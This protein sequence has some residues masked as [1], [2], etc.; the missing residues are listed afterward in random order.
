MRAGSAPIA[1][2]AA[3]LRAAGG[4]G[5]VAV[6]AYGSH[7]ISAAPGRHS[8]YDLVVVVE[9]YTDFYSTLRAS[10]HSRRNAT[11]L[12]LVS[13]V[14]PPTVIAF[15]PAAPNG[16][17]AKCAVVSRAHFARELGRRRRD[18][19]CLGRMMQQVSVVYTRDE[20]AAAWVAA[21]VAGGRNLVPDWTLPFLDAPFSVDAFCRCMLEVSYAGEIRPE[22]G[23]RV[24]AVYEA[25]REFLRDTYRPV[26]DARVAS[27]VL[28]ASDG[29]Y[30]PVV[31]PSRLAR[32]R[33]NA[34]FAASKARA[35]IRWLKHMMTFD[36]WSSYVVRKV[37]RRTGM[38]VEITPMERRLPFPL[39]LPKVLRVLRARDDPERIRKVAGSRTETGTVA[40][41]ERPES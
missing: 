39:L 26:L 40:R 7:V 6:V 20:K 31:H 18:H 36:N 22:Q 15:R 25:Q 30:L 29:R 23:S 24:S 41:A 8:A 34:Y 38:T 1:E 17:L 37:E 32:L 5:L 14:L 3:G 28:E 16:P 11:W 12:A 35:T 13:R 21:R 2:L 27:G 10:G 19:F 33:W 9:G 4:Q